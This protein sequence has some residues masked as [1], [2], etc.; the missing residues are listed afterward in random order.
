MKGQR[1]NQEVGGQ[2]SGTERSGSGSE[3]SG[4]RE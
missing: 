2:G 3:R 4:V 1:V